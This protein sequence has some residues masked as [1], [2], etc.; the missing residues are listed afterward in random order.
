MKDIDQE[1]CDRCGPAVLAY[2]RLGLIAGDLHFCQHHAREV[3][4]LIVGL[5]DCYVWSFAG[6]DLSVEQ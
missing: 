4:G 2:A 6:D 3:A 5:V 1:T